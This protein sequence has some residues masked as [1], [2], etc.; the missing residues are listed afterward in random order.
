MSSC[1]FPGQDPSGPFVTFPPFPI[2]R[3]SKHGKL[4]SCIDPCLPKK[5]VERRTVGPGRSTFPPFSVPDLVEHPD[6]PPCGF[7][8]E[9]VPMSMSILIVAGRRVS[10]LLS[11]LRP[12][13]SH[14]RFAAPPLSDSNDNIPDNSMRTAYRFIILVKFTGPPHQP[15]EDVGITDLFFIR[16]VLLFLV[17]GI[18]VSSTFIFRPLLP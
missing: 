8:L 2:L 5:M 15:K 14:H 11:F 6:F 18:P 7:F 12:D 16:V 17:P 10:P 4:P 9:S 1:C 3:L 13:F